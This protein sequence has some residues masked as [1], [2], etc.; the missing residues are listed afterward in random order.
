MH[1]PTARECAH[2]GEAVADELYVAIIYE[3]EVDAV[4]CW[5]G[6]CWAST[7]NTIDLWKAR[8]AEQNL[9]ELAE[10]R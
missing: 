10:D 2:C 6:C 1:L 5:P 8:K 7:K 4:F 9:D 3:G